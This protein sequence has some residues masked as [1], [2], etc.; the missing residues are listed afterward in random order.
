MIYASLFYQTVVRKLDGQHFL[1]FSRS[2]TSHHPSIFSPQ[3]LFENGRV[4]NIFM[5][6]FYIKFSNEFTTMLK[7]FE[8][9][10]AVGGESASKCY[11]LSVFLV[12]MMLISVLCKHAHIFFFLSAGYIHSRVE[13]EFLWDCKQLGAYS[14]IVLLNTLLFFCCKYFGFTTVQQHRQLSFA[15]VMRCTKTN[16][17]YTKT[18]YLRFYP[19]IP[20]NE[21]ES[22]TVLDHSLSGI[23]K[24]LFLFLFI[25]FAFRRMLLT[26]CQ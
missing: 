26:S 13:E 23:L 4:E 16:Q 11:S 8:P 15:H 6:R 18:T 21:T 17:N 1:Y 3:H 10:I 19:P 9:S 24:S 14:P 12:T 22:G 25:L 5:D 7:R 20:A 2:S